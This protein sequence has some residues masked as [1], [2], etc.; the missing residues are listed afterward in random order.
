MRSHELTLGRSFGVCFD[1]GDAFFDALAKFCRSNNGC[2]SDNTVRSENFWW[3]IR[4]GPFVA[5][6]LRLQRRAR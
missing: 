4:C 5:R 2:P 1:H 3:A 6:I